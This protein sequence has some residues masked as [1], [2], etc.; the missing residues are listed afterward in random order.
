MGVSLLLAALLAQ[1]PAEFEDL[2]IPA[3]VLVDQVELRLQAGG[4]PK[5]LEEAPGLVLVR[6][7]QRLS[8][9]AVRRS[10]ERLMETGRFADVEVFAEEVPEG[11]RVVFDLR[12]K[13]T[14]GAIYVEGNFA[15]TDAEVLAPTRLTVESEFYPERI[16]QAR[17]AVMQL[18]RRRGYR[19]VKVEVQE[20]EGEAGVDVGFFIGEGLPTRIKALIVAGDPGLPLPRLMRELDLSLGQVIDVGAIEASLERLK[21]TLR[22]EHFYR[23]RVDPAQI[24]E[25]GVVV[26]PISAGPRLDLAFSGN[27]AFA[28]R[29]LSRV[30]AWDGGELMDATVADRLAAQLANFYRYRGYH[31]V[32]VSVRERPGATPRSA[33][34]EFVIEEGPQLFVRSVTFTGNEGLSSDELRRVLADVIT[35]GTPA[36][37]SEVRPVDDP[38]QLEGKVKPPRFGDPPAP[39]PETVMVEAAYLEAAK[40]MGRLYRERGYAK[41]LVQLVSVDFAKAGA[42]VRFGVVE[43]PQTRMRSVSFADG[44]PGFPEVNAGAISAGEP[45]SER[46]LEG[47]VQGL[48]RELVRRGYHYGTVTPEVALAEN[49]TRADVK[50]VVSKGP[51][52]TVGKVLVRGNQRTF[53]SVVRSQLDFT[54]GEPLDP[55]KLYTSQRNLLGLGIFRSADVRILA[56]ETRDAVKDIIVEVRERQRI[57]GEAGLGYYLAEGPRG[58]VDVEFPNLAGR[59]INLQARVKINMFAASGLALSRQV[60]VSDLNA[61]EQLGGAGNI[62]VSNRGL[63]PFGI[64]TRVDIVGERVFRQSYRFTR[65][66]AGPG[67]DW[68]HAFNLGFIDWTR[69]K[70]TLQLQYEAEW[71]RVSR[72]NNASGVI[73]PLLRADQERLRFLFGTFALNTVRFAPTIDLR[74]DV[75][76]PRKGL[77]LQAAIE[78]TWAIETRDEEQQPVPVQFLKV[79]GTATTYVPLYRKLVLALS[80]RAGTIIPLVENSVTPPVKRFY[81]GGSSSLRGFREDGLIADDQRQDYRKQINDCKVLATNIGCTPAAVTLLGRNE[82]AS[83]GG[84]VFVLGKAELRLPAFGPVDLGLFFEA[85]NLWLSPPTGFSLRPVAGAGLRYLTPIGP[86]ALD[87]GVNLFPDLLVNEPAFNVHFNIGLF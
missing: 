50:F 14:I 29:S 63:L 75:V 61:L 78:T 28:P 53:E 56:P 66:A 47:W 80:A 40:A 77:L 4:D 23:A 16:I 32:K 31:D 64:G 35:S 43:G 81:L 65:F 67:I 11:L 38:L 68:S 41:A 22:V 74:D 36:L 17:E 26:L 59:A 37:G 12:S 33:L 83:Q 60:D 21:E 9:R 15:L 25:G 46:R 8:P 24:E 2:K 72:V 55:E 58:V 49:E 30:L 54:E 1:A 79:S 34:L 57:S 86:L 39:A 73:F 71:S 48:E 76:V 85:G 18:Y 19:D 27:V 52:V 7:G 6:K 13:Q 45:L 42:A 62:S 70:L 44:P 20:T 84:E 10:I 3:A 5:L 51:Q 69:P 82:V 87:F